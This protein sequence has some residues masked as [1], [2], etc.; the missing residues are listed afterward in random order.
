[1]SWEPLAWS[2]V[3]LTRDTFS[4]TMGKSNILRT[5][6]LL[7]QLFF[8][9]ISPYGAHAVADM[10]FVFIATCRSRTSET[11]YGI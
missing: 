11:C 2:E 5:P 9:R 10:W 6:K 1:M 7:K 8:V 4:S 3:G